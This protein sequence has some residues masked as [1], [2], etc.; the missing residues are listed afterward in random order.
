MVCL[1]GAPDTASAVAMVREDAVDSPGVVMAQVD[2]TVMVLELVLG[3]AHDA[4]AVDAQIGGKFCGGGTSHDCEVPPPGKYESMGIRFIFLILLALVVFVIPEISA[5]QPWRRGMHDAYERPPYGQFCPGMR[6]DPYGAKKPV[7][8]TDEARQVL[9]QYFEN[10]GK[11]VGIGTIEER[12]WF[13]VAEV[14]DAEGSLI[15]KA[16]IDKRTGRIR[17]IY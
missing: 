7:R 15:D 4:A 3:M 16:I 8:T 13:F 11:K 2:V 1:T 9:E 6:G 10:T 5:A 12:R 14:L 17:S